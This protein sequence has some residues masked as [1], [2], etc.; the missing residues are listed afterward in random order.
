[1]ADNVELDLVKQGAKLC[2]TAG[3]LLFGM[4]M[5]MAPIYQDP[6]K[7]ATELLNS[8][9]QFEAIADAARKLA[10]DICDFDAASASRIIRPGNGRLS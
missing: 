3:R 7:V 5:R 1:M 10:S 4:G 6:K 2:E 8:A 9:D